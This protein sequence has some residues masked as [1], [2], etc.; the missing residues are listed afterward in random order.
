MM[1]EM[2]WGQEKSFGKGKT[3][4]EGKMD[5]HRTREQKY[6]RKMRLEAINKERRG[7]VMAGKG[8]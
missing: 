5:T 6:R 4:C 2:L 3:M 7:Q 8:T 1:T